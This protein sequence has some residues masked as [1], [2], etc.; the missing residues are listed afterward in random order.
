VLQGGKE[1]H[2]LAIERA[3]GPSWRCPK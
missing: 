3:R 2:D 1:W